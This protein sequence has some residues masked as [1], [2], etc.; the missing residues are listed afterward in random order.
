MAL[1]EPFCKVRLAILLKADG[2]YRKL[3]QEREPKL[4]P[5]IEA[6]TAEG[7]DFDVYRRSDARMKHAL[8]GE[9]I[10]VR[11][12]EDPEALAAEKILGQQ[13]NLP[14]QVQVLGRL[15]VAKARAEV[16]P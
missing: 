6:G 3:W 12:R 4:L 2:D 11:L 7:F 1:L 16:D 10:K 15:Q 8:R 9:Y 13:S 14:Q 5:E